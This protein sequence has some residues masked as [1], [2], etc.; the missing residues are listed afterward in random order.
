MASIHRV[1]LQISNAVPV[2]YFGGLKRSQHTRL[3]TAA[4]PTQ[5]F[6]PYDMLAGP[7]APMW[8]L[9]MIKQTTFYSNNLIV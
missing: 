3:P 2:W 7:L 4:R 1:S 8:V 5:R 6:N 9:Q